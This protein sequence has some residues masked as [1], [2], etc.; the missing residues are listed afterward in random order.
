MIK[1]VNRIID[2]IENVLVTTLILTATLTAIGQVIARYVF[3]NSL[4]WSEELILYALI[5]MSF[6]TMGMGVRYASHISVEAIYAIAGPRTARA[7]QIGATC[8]GL[9]FACVLVFYGLKLSFNTMQ[10]GQLSPA[11]RIPVGYIYL[12]IPISGGLMAKL[13]SLVV[14]ASVNSTMR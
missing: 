12:I 9:V 6:L 5:T 13:D 7:L 2:W 1:G 4:Y 11:M 8:L 3:N 10:M 14:S